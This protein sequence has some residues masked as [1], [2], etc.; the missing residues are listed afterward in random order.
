MRKSDK[1]S[2]S[3]LIQVASS[4]H[5]PYVLT[6]TYIR[7]SG[8]LLDPD[9]PERLIRRERRSAFRFFLRIT[10]YVLCFISPSGATCVQH[11]INLVISSSC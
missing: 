9:D 1:V 8:I 2:F 10:Y 6:C 11:R 7:S 4:R 3:R 5:A